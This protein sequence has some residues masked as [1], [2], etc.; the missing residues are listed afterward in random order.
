MTNDAQV[1]RVLSALAQTTRLGVFR[2]LMQEGEDGLAAGII[3]DRLGVPQNTLSSHLSILSNAGL[4]AA[5]REGRSL[6]YS[7]NIATTREFL[8]YL[9]SDCCH[10]HPEI[11]GMVGNEKAVCG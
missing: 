9:V 10:G 6:I 1:V 5:R 8:D 3:A 4:I 7:V 11:C 2:L